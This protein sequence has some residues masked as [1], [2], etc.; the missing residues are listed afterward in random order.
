M[1]KFVEVKPPED[2]CLWQYNFS[3][4]TIVARQYAFGQFRLQV[5]CGSGKY[6]PILIPEC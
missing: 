3:N 6:P 5:W 1:S 2:G 4:I